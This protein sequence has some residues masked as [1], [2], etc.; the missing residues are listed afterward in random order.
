MINSD[1]QGCLL[2]PILFSMFVKEFTKIVETNGL[3]GIQLHLELIEI[4][5]LLFADD[6]ALVADTIGGLQCQLCLLSTFCKEKK[7][8]VHVGKTKVPVFWKGGRKNCNERWNYN[9]EPLEVVNGFRYDGL[10]FTSNISLFSMTE[11]LASKGKRV[12]V[13]LLNSLYHYGT[14]P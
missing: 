11:D 6:I 13:Y 8:T 9:G 3:H 12:L 14:M 4:F 10:L 5:I 1:V 7:I 2:S